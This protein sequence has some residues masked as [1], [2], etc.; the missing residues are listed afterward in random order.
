[1]STHKGK[2]KIILIFTLLFLAVTALLI[3]IFFAGKKT[4]VVRY[5]INGG[6]LISGSL[7]QHI[8]QG[9]NAIPPTVVKDGAYLHSW[10]ASSDHI[11][12]DMVITAV[13]NYETTKGII[14]SAGGSQNFAEIAGAYKYISGE[15]YLGSYYGDKRILGIGGGAFENCQRITKIYLLDGLLSIG[16]KA[17]SNCTSLT[18]IEIPKTVSHLGS[19]ALKGCE[20][21]EVAVLHEGLLEIGKSAFEGCT[22]LKEIVIP[23]TVKSIGENAFLGCESLEKVIFEGELEQIPNSAFNGCSSLTE[24]VLPSTIK[25]IGNRAFAS[26]SSLKNLTLNDG[27]LIIGREAFDGCESLKEIEVP[28]SVKSVGKDAF[29]RCDE[30]IIIINA[31]EGTRTPL[32]W[33]EGWNGNTKFITMEEHQEDIE[34]GESEPD[35]T[36]DTGLSD[37]TEE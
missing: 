9:Q 33:A 2:L 21:L 34:N 11:T 26:C 4:Y 3:L 30:L 18:E 17:F 20:K 10:S 6:T 35:N 19:E 5:D 12:K 25:E 36:E 8:T 27:L 37:K 31:P 7:E 23:S 28:A 16:S 22:S 1:M 29:S 32:G 15:V 13:W 24:I 14:Y